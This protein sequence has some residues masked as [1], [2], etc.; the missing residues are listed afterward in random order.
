VENLSDQEIYFNACHSDLLTLQGQ[1]WAEVPLDRICADYA[2]ILFPHA[3]AEVPAWQLPPGIHVGLYRLR[4]RGA[5]AA[6]ARSVL[7]ERER[8]TETFAIVSP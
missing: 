2:N 3:A 8:T 5:R 1:L 7:S 4:L 6:S